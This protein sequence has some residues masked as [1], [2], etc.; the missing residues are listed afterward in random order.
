MA[1]QAWIEGTDLLSLE[2]GTIAL[3]GIT[4]YP[5]NGS[6]DK[7]VLLVLV[8]EAGNILNANNIG[9]PVK[10]E[11]G[12]RMV[13]TSENHLAITGRIQQAGEGEANILFLTVDLQLK[14][15]TAPMELPTSGIA[16][17]LAIEQGADN[18]LLICGSGEHQKE[19]G[20]ETDRDIILVAI[21]PEGALSWGPAFFGDEGFDTGVSLLP[22]ADGIAL[23]GSIQFGSNTMMTLIKTDLQGSL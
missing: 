13:H 10:D 20:Q 11:I 2:D 9:S 15:V 5:E 17:G 19:D 12:Y 6:L 8:N 16:S 7:D 18:S 14:P 22:L 23:L 21:T 3:L 1:I 4:D